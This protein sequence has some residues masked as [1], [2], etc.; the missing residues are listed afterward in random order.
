[1]IHDIE[2]GSSNMNWCGCR[3][4]WVTVQEFNARGSQ[5]AN[6]NDDIERNLG[7]RLI[8]TLVN[9]VINFMDCPSRKITSFTGRMYQHDD[10]IKWKN[11][12]RYWHFVRRIHRSPVESHR[13]GQ[14]RGDFGIFFGLPLNKWLSK[15]WRRRWFE[16]PLCSLWRHCKWIF[17]SRAF[18][19]NAAYIL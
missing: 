17:F 7:E 8:A 3:G 6:V 1:M 13:K 10:V 15:Q 2:G 18:V 4:S 19:T 11:F 12:A 14:W 16:T 5:I 9:E